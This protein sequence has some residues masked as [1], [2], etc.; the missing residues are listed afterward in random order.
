MRREA[1]YTANAKRKKY[2][3]QAPFDDA[4]GHW[5]WAQKIKA[6]SYWQLAKKF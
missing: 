4:K 1:T 6:V 3:S 2:R 5:V